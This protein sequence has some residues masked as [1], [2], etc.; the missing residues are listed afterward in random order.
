MRSK[1]GGVSHFCSAWKVYGV[2]VT[3]RPPFTDTW[4]LVKGMGHPQ[5]PRQTDDHS[6]ALGLCCCRTTQGITRIEQDIWLN[7]KGRVM[8]LSLREPADGLML[9]SRQCH[10]IRCCGGKVDEP[11]MVMGGSDRMDIQ[12]DGGV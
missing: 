4:S 6:C 12:I 5:L 8:Q 7:A 10:L 1:L 9:I 3:V 11:D 2:A